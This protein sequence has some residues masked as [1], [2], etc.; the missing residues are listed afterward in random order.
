[1][2]GTLPPFFEITEDT[3]AGY[4]AVA[5]YTM[6]VLMVVTIAVRLF[7]R[8]YVARVVHADDILLG[9]GTVRAIGYQ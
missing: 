5:V 2:A 6:L 9:A 8:W 1:M 3:H 4:V 7:T